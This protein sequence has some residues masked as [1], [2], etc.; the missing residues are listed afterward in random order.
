MKYL[1][2][3]ALLASLITYSIFLKAQ[4]HKEKLQKSFE[5]PSVLYLLNVNGGIHLQGSST[6][7]IVVE[8]EKELKAK[9]QNT[10]ER[11][12]GEVTL[13]HLWRGDTLILYIQTPFMAL[14]YK[15][16]KWRYNW[17]NYKQK[18]DYDYTLNFELQVP[19]Q[20]NIHLS[21][22]N[23]GDIFVE[24]ISAPMDIRNI[25]GSIKLE[26]VSG[27]TSAHTINGDVDIFYRQNPTKDSD[28]Y[29]LNG[30]LNLFFQ[31]NL[32]ADATFKSF[33]GEFYSHFDY[34][35]QP[36]ELKRTVASN[37]AKTTYKVEKLTRIRINR[38]GPTF[39][40]ETFNGDAYLKRIGER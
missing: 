5:T 9:H 14:A 28:Y 39:T 6:Q 36:I 22:I 34:E 3:F 10:L 8:A 37:K 25:N 1:I 20:T 7:E 11:A 18:S 2:K 30:D 32:S 24:H 27:Q 13:E 40:I 15:H 35:L 12:I 31:E 17:E 21:T 38:G 26:D 33:N 19:A 4:T 29:T 23:R 16:G